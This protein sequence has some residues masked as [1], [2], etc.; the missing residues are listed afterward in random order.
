MTSIFNVTSCALLLQQRSFINPLRFRLH[1][2][3]CTL[4]L[5]HASTRTHERGLSV[6][7]SR[8]RNMSP[9]VCWPLKEFEDVTQSCHAILL[10]KITW[11]AKWMQGMFVVTSPFVT[12]TRSVF[13]LCLFCCCCCCCFFFCV[14]NQENPELIWN[15]EAREKICSVVKQ[16]KDR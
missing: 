7:T 15:T 6:H 14:A 1:Q 5:Q 4:S 3:A 16:L 13:D 12:F 10:R 9:S 8:S 2:L 11:Q